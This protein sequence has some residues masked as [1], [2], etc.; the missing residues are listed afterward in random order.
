MK[1]SPASIE[2]NATAS[3]EQKAPALASAAE[4]IF[5]SKLPA[6]QTNKENKMNTSSKYR[7]TDCLTDIK[8][9]DLDALIDQATA[10]RWHGKMTIWKWNGRQWKYVRTFEF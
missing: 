5:H 9:N 6:K 2:R 3:A 8:G 1:K 10:K 7:I 4:N